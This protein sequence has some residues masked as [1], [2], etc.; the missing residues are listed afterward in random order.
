MIIAIAVLHNLEI[1]QIDVKIAFLNRDLDEEIYMEQL[2]GFIAL[3]LEKK[4]CKLVKL[5]YGLK[6]AQ[7]QWHEKFDHT[8]ITNG[9]KIN[10]C[11][12]CVYVK[13]IKNS[14]HFMF[15]C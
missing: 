12:K 14:C 5:L 9:F 4:V 13:E 7:K 8:M 11:D 1:Y 6:Q 10:E 2:E 3:G 15:I